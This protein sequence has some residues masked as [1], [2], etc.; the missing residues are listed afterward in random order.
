MEKLRDMKKDLLNN[1]MKED[2]RHN[3]LYH[4][5][6]DNFAEKEKLYGGAVDAVNERTQPCY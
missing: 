5:L 6:F 2:M 3:Y 4:I 1:Q